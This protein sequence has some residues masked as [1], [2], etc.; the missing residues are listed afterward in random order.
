MKKLLVRFFIFIFPIILLGL[1]AEIL[2]RKIPNDYL[3]K[4][5]YLDNTSKNIEVL[6]LGSSH[7]FYGINPEYIN[8]KSFNAAYLSQTLNYDFEILKKYENKWTN[9]KYIVMPVDYSS[10]YFKLEASVEA[11]RV[12]GYVIYYGI[13]TCSNIVVHTEILSTKLRTNI[14]RLYRFYYKHIPGITSS[15]LGWGTGFNSKNNRDLIVTGKLAAERHHAG[16]ALFFNENVETLRSI[17][18]FARAKNIKIL[19]LTSPA[20]KTYTQNLDNDQLSQTIK[21]LTEIV[22]SYPN[23]FYFNLLNDS[24]FTKDDFFDGDHLNE[25]GAKKLTLKVDSLLRINKKI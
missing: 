13:N 3:Y 16:N 9:L 6:F 24:T 23:T 5:N 22:R 2:L 1:S 4:S 10:L 11:W 19:F 17:I 15:K 25:I 12:K 18:S 7:T 14:S 20:Y 8:A 21:T